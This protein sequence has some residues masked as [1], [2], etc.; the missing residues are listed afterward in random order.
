M[1]CG[2]AVKRDLQKL[3]YKYLVFPYYK[4][5][6]E[7]IFIRN[8]DYDEASCCYRVLNIPQNINEK[9]VFDSCI[10]PQVPEKEKGVDLLKRLFWLY[11]RTALKLP[12]IS[13]SLDFCA[14]A[15]LRKE[16]DDIGQCEIRDAV[17]VCEKILSVYQCLSKAC[18]VNT[19]NCRE[20]AFYDSNASQV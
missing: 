12:A 19:I 16:Y 7:L 2:V 6:E 1:S 17:L 5:P 11:N 3:Y 4:S 9:K 15:H 18:K 20:M 13:H 10:Y 14:Q 8:P